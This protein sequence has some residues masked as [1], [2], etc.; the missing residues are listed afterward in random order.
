MNQTKTKY[1]LIL[2]LI[3][4]IVGLTVYFSTKNN[5]NRLAVTN[6]NLQGVEN[7]YLLEMPNLNFQI[8]FPQEPKFSRTDGKDFT[9]YTWS[10]IDNFGNTLFLQAE[11]NLYA[12]NPTKRNFVEEVA[13]LYGG[14]IS[15]YEENSNSS[16]VTY[17]IS[18][19]Y[20]QS[21]DDTD[22]IIGKMI[23]INEWTFVITNQYNKNNQYPGFITSFKRID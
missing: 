17:Q 22:T 18:G 13:R 2:I 8:S 10:Y 14:V 21:T 16:T 11:N 7:W 6:K 5:N 20:S 4:F 15:S 9:R 12:Y 1:T 3:I 23:D 19:V